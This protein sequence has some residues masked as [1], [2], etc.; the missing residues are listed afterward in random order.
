MGLCST[1]LLCVLQFLSVGYRLCSASLTFPEFKQLL[2]REGRGYK[3][4]NHQRLVQPPDRVLLSFNFRELGSYD[5]DNF[6]SK[7]GIELPQLGV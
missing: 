7:W 5:C 1:D 2:I 6:L 4:R 3:N